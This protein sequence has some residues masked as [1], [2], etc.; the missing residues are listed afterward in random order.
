MIRYAILII[1]I[2]P[3]LYG[4]VTPQQ[5]DYYSESQGLRNKIFVLESQNKE[6]NTQIESLQ[7]ALD[8]EAKENAALTEKID[9]LTGNKKTASSSATIIQVQTALKNAGY[10]PGPIDGKTGSRTRKAM[11]YFQQSEGLP[12]TGVC[13]KDTWDKL[14]AYLENKNAQEENTQEEKE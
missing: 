7:A 12:I 3:L 11:R 2:A 1:S 8:Q 9:A 14:K 10:D 4:C 5:K 6:K 13:D